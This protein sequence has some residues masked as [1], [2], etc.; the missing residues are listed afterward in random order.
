MTKFKYA[1]MG[2]TILIVAFWAYTIE[3]ILVAEAQKQQEIDQS[4]EITADDKIFKTIHVQ[5]EDGITSPDDI[6]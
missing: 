3:I 2:L 5:L 4:Q 6:Q 1:L